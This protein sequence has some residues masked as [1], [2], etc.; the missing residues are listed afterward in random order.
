MPVRVRKAIAGVGTTPALVTAAPSPHAPCASSASIHPPDSR[1]S[2]PT[3]NWGDA[4]PCGSARTNAAP[5]R[6]TAG[7]SSGGVPASPRMPSVPNNLLFATGHP[8]LDRVG[9]DARHAGI[10]RRVGVDGQRVLAGTEPREVDERGEIVG[11]H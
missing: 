1:V 9:R 3:R 4:V 11:G 8:Y 6:R 5:R 2:R 10:A 7:G